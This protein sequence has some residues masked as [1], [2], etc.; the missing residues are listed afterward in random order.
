MDINLNEEKELVPKIIVR[1]ST[2]IFQTDRGLSCRKDINFLQRKC[3]GFNFVK[4]DISIMDAYTV[5]EAIINIDEV[6]DGIYEMII[7]NE[8]KDWETGYIDSWDYKLISYE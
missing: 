6:E 8:Q 5:Y 3:I 7:C 4:E 2:H 1:V